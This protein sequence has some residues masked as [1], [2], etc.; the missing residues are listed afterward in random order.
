MLRINREL[1]SS[2]GV[3]SA[4]IALGEISRS[5]CD[6]NAARDYY[7]EALQ[8]NQDLGQIG[9]VMVVAHNLGY[10]A[11]Q[12]NDLEQALEFFR[13][14]LDLGQD[15]SVRRFIYYCVA[16][17]ACVYYELGRY[18]EALQLFSAVDKIGSENEYSFDP[19]DRLEVEQA[20]NGLEGVISSE[21]WKELWNS[22][23]KLTIEQVIAIAKDEHGKGK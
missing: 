1:R 4:L 17:I 3:G 9:I 19:V 18:E 7:E 6:F 5:H 23:Q 13:H 22:G 8:I 14:S 15:R 21:Q 12:Q 10:V 20:R 16:G 2:P 11:K